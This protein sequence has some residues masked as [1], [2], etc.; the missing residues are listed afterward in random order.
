MEECGN[1]SQAILE[2]LTSD[3]E[4]EVLRS[5]SRYKSLVER[6]EQVAIK[7]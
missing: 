4:T 2:W 7:P 1:R 6:L 3:D 5:D